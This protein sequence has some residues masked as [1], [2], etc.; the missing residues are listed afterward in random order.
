MQVE[1]NR[2]DECKRKLNI[3][4]PN[5]VVS[6]ELSEIY[7]EINQRANIKGFRKGK[8]P[9]K[10]LEQLYKRDA[11]V[12]L[13]QELVPK[14]CEEV[15][16]ANNLKTAGD[17]LLEKYELK[18]GEGLKLDIS[19][20]V[21]PDMSL[22]N[23][24]GLKIQGKSTDV[25]DEDLD[26]ALKQMQYDSAELKTVESRGAENGDEM[27]LDFSGKIDG[28]IFDGGEGKDFKMILGDKKMLEG[29]E[30]K[31]LG[32]K[33]GEKKD[34][35]IT[36]PQDTPNKELAGKKVVFEVLVKDIKERNLP[37]LNDEFAKDLGDYN[38]LNTLKEKI[39]NDIKNTKEY[40][41]KL[42]H[43]KE[44][45]EKILEENPLI[46]PGILVNKEF[47][48]LKKSLASRL[49]GGKADNINFGKE[50]EKIE[51]E[52]LKEAEKRVKESLLL[53]K[54]ADEEKIT[55]EDREVDEEI[56]KRAES[57]NQNFNVLK[58]AFQQN[59]AYEVIR[60]KIREEKVLNFLL[61]CSIV[62]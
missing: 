61:N 39:R 51:Q 18:E 24:K 30:D 11:E 58:K 23:Y 28:K 40:Y 31:L 4:I 1:I 27:V 44:I 20:E 22:K 41:N 19:V 53:E 25:T 52:L 35:E 45:V 5:D 14:A 8:V 49:S 26:T 60:S 57:M 10:V 16:I 32:A 48:F 17:Y 7:Q 33:I 55:V 37:Q 21:I 12:S 54:I 47:E 9:R 50:S 34:V 29:F 6:K 62:S 59:E 36:Y 15:F 56:R 38:D 43:Q 2:V 13:L 42:E 46:P 3:T